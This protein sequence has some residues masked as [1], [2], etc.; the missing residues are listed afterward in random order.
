MAGRESAVFKLPS[1]RLALDPCD[2]IHL[3]HDGRLTVF[4][5]ISVGDAGARSIEA[6]RQDRAVY[7]LLPGAARAATVARQVTFGM[8][9]VLFLDLPHLSDSIPAH[10]PLIAADAQPWPGEMAVFRSPA[11]DRFTLLSIVATVRTWATSKS[12]TPASRR[13]RHWSMERQVLKSIRHWHRH[14]AN[15]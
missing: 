2:V 3:D 4:Q 5:L 7:D 9:E 8:P 14:M 6:R 10:Q 12:S 11:L 1:F 13:I 15:T